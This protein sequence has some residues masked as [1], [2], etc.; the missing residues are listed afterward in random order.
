MAPRQ[1]IVFIILVLC[2][3]LPAPADVTLRLADGAKQRTVTLKVKEGL[4]VSPECFKKGAPCEALKAHSK[5]Q[6]LPA[7][8]V[9]ELYGHPAARYCMGLGGKNRIGLAKDSGQVD[10]CAFADGSMA[11]AWQLFNKA[12]PQGKIQPKRK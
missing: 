1:K 4:L 3:A 2:F 12:H 6:P 7:N 8:A 9:P 11:D 5:A 10:L